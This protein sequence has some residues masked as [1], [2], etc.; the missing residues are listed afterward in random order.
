MGGCYTELIGRARALEDRVRYQ[1]FF[2]QTKRRVI[3]ASQQR[4]VL[5]FYPLEV[6]PSA[7]AV[8]R[9]KSRVNQIKEPKEVLLS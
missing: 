1:A 2:R 6:L 8:L 4:P 9:L 3:P 7:P 5:R